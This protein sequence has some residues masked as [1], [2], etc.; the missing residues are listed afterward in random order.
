MDYTTI[1][2]DVSK[3]K[4]DICILLSGE[5]IT[6]SNDNKGFA[7]LLKHIQKNYTVK[8]IIIEHTGNYQKNL[9]LYLHKYGYTVCVVNP[10][11]VRSF[12]KACGIL[13]KT[14]KI[15]AYV[16]AQ[17]G[18]LL[19]PEETTE[20]SENVCHL[21][22]LVNLRKQLVETIKQFKTRL[23]KNPTTYILKEI[24]KTISYLKKQQ[25][26]IEKQILDFV[27]KQEEFN[28]KY[29]ILSQISG[30]GVQTITTLLS[31]LPELGK[32]ERN[33]IVA[34]CGLAPIN[35]DSGTM[36]GNRSIYGG[37]KEVRNSLYMAA[38]SAI[39]HNPVIKAFYLNL[40]K[41][42]KPSKVALVA[43]MRKI[44]C[45]ANSLAKNT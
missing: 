14:D 24:S 36:R 6:V 2:I 38:V 23:E 12:A 19:N 41:N 43:C 27:K 9:V 35:R 44:L 8:K 26:N 28:K 13:A 18:E 22:D 39:R 1:G 33:K 3:A 34:L 37:R 20:Q 21:K 11:K 10:S 40:K 4:L 30:F 29:E 25:T 5:I 7:K 17:Y 31:Y 45:Y 42:G 15:D 32:I 16:I